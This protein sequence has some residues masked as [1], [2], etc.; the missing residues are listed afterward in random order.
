MD[1]RAFF[2]CLIYVV[3]LLKGVRHD[4]TVTVQSSVRPVTHGLT[5]V[6]PHPAVDW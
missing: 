1:A 5:S 3:K 6:T 4:L 2:F